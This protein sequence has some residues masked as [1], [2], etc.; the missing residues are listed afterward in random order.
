MTE[1]RNR[2]PDQ[3]STK[4]QDL[5]NPK[6][7]VID[8]RQQQ[9]DPAGKHRVD[10]NARSDSNRKQPGGSHPHEPASKDDKPT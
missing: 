7:G 1:E 8:Q 9:I 2:R 5:R 3:S 10:R 4:T 6:P